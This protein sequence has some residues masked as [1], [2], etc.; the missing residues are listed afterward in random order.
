MSSSPLDSIQ[1]SAWHNV[2]KYLIHLNKRINE[3]TETRLVEYKNPKLAIWL[4]EKSSGVHQENEREM[5]Y[6]RGGQGIRGQPTSFWLC[7]RNLVAHFDVHS[8]R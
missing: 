5:E 2:S 7:C 3:K 8:L 6:G 4:L 1:Q